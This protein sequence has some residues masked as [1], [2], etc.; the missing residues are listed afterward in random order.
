MSIVTM[1]ISSF[2]IERNVSIAG[3]DEVISA[4][5]SAAPGLQ[6]LTENR[7]LN[8]MPPDM[9]AVNANVFI[10]RMYAYR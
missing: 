10:K 7:K 1:N 9:A 5:F 8:A 3:D 2:E 6:P 4:N